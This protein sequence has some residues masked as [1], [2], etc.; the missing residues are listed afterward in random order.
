MTVAPSSSI[1]TGPTSSSLGGHAQCAVGYDAD[2]LWAWSSW[3]MP[4]VRPNTGTALFSGSAG[5]VLPAPASTADNTAYVTYYEDQQTSDCV[6]C[7]FEGAHMIA[8][9]GTSKRTSPFSW[10]RGARLRERS[11]TGQA[12]AD[13]GCQPIDAANAAISVGVYPRDANDDNPTT[14]NQAETWHELA[15]SQL[16]LPDHFALVDD[17]DVETMRAHLTAGNGLVF[18]MQVDESYE[19]FASA[20]PIARIS[21][22]FVASS[23]SS[24]IA[25]LGGPV[26]K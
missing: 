21:W 24:C 8:T 14:V 26:Y 2:A 19:A 20:N 13:D 11:R 12:L 5:L 23:V 9:K 18:C 22:S 7:S 4:S 15:G 1:W 3:I 17:G 6:G 25:V 10:Y 16:F